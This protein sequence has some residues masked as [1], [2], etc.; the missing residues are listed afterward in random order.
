MDSAI[1]T[2]KYRPTDFKEIKGQKEIVEKIKAFVE[3]KNMPH[4][5]FSGPAGVG[6]TTLSLVI[7]KQLFGEHWR[8]N[9]LELNASDERGIDIIRV[10]V[11]DFARTKAIGNV[12]FKLIYLDECDA[13]TKE[14]QQALRR[15]MENYTKTARFIL[16]CNYSS[17]ILDPIQSRCAVFRFKPLSREEIF[18]VIENVAEEEKL[19][20][21]EEVKQA[22]FDVC[23]GDCRRLENIL[24][25]CA[26]LN[27]KI[28]PEA[29][30][31]MASVAKPKEV[32]E[33]LTAAAEG[34]FLEARKKL[35]NLMLDYG[36]S[37]LDVIRQIQKEIWNLELEDRKKVE[38][39]DKCGEVEFRMVEGSDEYIQLESFLAY[40]ML[41]GRK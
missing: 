11:K 7:A 22:L 15:T 20:I 13:L 29:V 37:G 26:V 4:L 9:T 32:N 12:P 23:N 16:S 33:V 10:K 6:K 8:Q 36:L 39:V 14:A 34:H 30:Y 5:L 25:S 21:S 3:S 18:A 40:A 27:Q 35:L 1:W 2:E 28:T 24:Q 17:K 41:V 31:S 38:L 19:V